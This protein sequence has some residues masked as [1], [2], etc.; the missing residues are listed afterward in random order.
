[1]IGHS[2]YSATAVAHPSLALVKYWG[3][4]R[5]GINIPATASLG[6]SLAALTTTTTVTLS[7]GDSVTV[8]GRR[9]DGERELARFVPVFEALRRE[10]AEPN[11]LPA[12]FG[13]EVVSKNDF[14]TAA[15]LASS[16]SG[17]AALVTAACAAAGRGDVSKRR[18]SEI[19]RI[20]SGSAARS[21]FGGFV[22]WEAGAVGAVEFRDD[23]WWPSL[24]VVVLPVSEGPKGLSSRDG[25]N[26]TRDTSPYYPAWVADAPKLVAACRD[27][28]EKRDLD[29]LGPIM[30]RSYL[31]MFGTMLAADPPVL[32]WLPATLA[33][34]HRLDALRAQGIPVWDTM[35]A[36]PQVK[37]FTT[38]EHVPALLE[39][40][41]ALCTAD[42]IVSTVG[43]P[44]RVVEGSP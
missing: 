26:R 40:C 4:E 24:R 20:G 35:D 11:G 33:V 25:M 9:L 30:R 27:A 38:E 23:R 29:A 42:P 15:G 43:G 18:R 41:S 12:D 37:V 1:M 34:L 28:V 14:P 21:V 17:F 3:K 10:L 19:A 5:T 31:R 16:A 36:G 8:D 22:L 7:D 13:F 6:V 32:Y 39:S 2:N 44:A